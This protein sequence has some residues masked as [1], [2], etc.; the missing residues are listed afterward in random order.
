MPAV[1]TFLSSLF[2]PPAGAT[3]THIIQHT[4]AR[5]SSFMAVCLLLALVASAEGAQCL[6]PFACRACQVVAAALACHQSTPDNIAQLCCCC[7]CLKCKLRATV[8]SAARA[9]P[10]GQALSAQPAAV[11]PA[12]AS[13][14]AGI[15]AEA[16][17]AT[18][19]LLRWGHRKAYAQAARIYHMTRARIYG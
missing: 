14:A 4:M 1:L 10:D 17:P 12:S 7:C 15:S 16:Q 19:M 9:L 6:R 3:L 18:R 2:S 11:A 8:A 13:L 5:S